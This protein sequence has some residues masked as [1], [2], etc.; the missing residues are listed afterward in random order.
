MLRQSS[1]RCLVLW[2]S[3]ALHA[4]GGPAIPPPNTP[5][6]KRHIQPTLACS[7]APSGAIWQS[8]L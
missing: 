6:P 8:A 2:R 7:G 5:R 4:D 1:S 3:A